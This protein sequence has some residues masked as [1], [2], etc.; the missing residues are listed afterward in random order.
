MKPARLSTGAG[1]KHPISEIA[2]LSIYEKQKYDHEAVSA[3]RVITGVVPVIP[4]G[5]GSAGWPG[6]AGHDNNSV[7]MNSEATPHLLTLRASGSSEAVL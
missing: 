5:T 4:L 1:R 3:F 7:I 2:K 6:Q